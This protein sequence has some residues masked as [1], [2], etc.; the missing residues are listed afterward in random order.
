M[1]VKDKLCPFFGGRNVG[2]IHRQGTNSFSIVG[3]LQTL[4]C[5]LLEV[6]PYLNNDTNLTVCGYSCSF[7]YIILQLVLLVYRTVLLLW[8][9]TLE[10]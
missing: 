3:Y 10:V 8:K 9:K 7:W 2:T 4:E 5:P 6:P 1:E